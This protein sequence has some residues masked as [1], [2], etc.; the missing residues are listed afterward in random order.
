MQEKEQHTHLN[1]TLVDIRFKQLPNNNSS[2]VATFQIGDKLVKD[3]YIPSFKFEGAVRE[4]FLQPIEQVGR[5][6][7]LNCKYNLHLSEDGYYRMEDTIL[8]YY[9]AKKGNIY[10]NYISIVCATVTLTNI[11]QLMHG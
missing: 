1:A 5:T 7:L 11:P 3:I 4:F 8:K 10:L 9:P 6:K 2:Y